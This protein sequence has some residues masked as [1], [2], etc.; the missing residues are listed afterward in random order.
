MSL[1]LTTIVLAIASTVM[2]G[3]MSLSSCHPSVPSSASTRLLRAIERVESGGRSDAVG[4]HGLAVGILQIH[5]ILVEDV[6]RISG[7]HFT[8]DDRLSP[9]RSEQMFWIWAGSRCR[10]ATDEQIARRWNGGPRGD[11]KQS[12][13]KY[14]EKVKNELD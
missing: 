10:G 8:L 6:N 7:R 11:T 2:D 13:K 12:T 4:D 9:E 1:A 3:G 5:P 14:W